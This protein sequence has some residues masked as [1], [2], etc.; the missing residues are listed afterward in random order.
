M[1]FPYPKTDFTLS[2][3]CGCVTSNA[4]ELLERTIGLTVDLRP[5][6][7]RPHLAIAGVP[8]GRFIKFPEEVTL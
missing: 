6:S 7:Y 1:L 2:I 4:D 3:K 5:S 8:K